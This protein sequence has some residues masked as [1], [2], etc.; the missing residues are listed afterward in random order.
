MA[1]I[2]FAGDVLI[3]STEDGGE[4]TVEDGLVADCRGFDSAV[5]LSLF[6]G[7]REDSAG[8]EKETWWGNL[9]P[10]TQEDE[11]LVSEFG[12]TI[13]GL[14]LTSGNL[15]KAQKAAERDLDWLKSVAGADELSV[16][17]SAEN[18]SQVTMTVEVK[19]NGEL[20]TGGEYDL[21][22]TEAVR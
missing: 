18:R 5:Y 21:Q 6:G 4:I 14:A 9:I 19:K 15:V 16:A 17:L 7:N 1:N 12:A 2:V 11:K 13:E 3:E 10:G 20:L 8:R 22:W